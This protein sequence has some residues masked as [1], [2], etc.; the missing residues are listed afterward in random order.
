[1]Q[2]RILQENKKRG[3]IR[4]VNNDNEK[5]TNEFKIFRIL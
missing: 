3:G 5:I 1:M 2:Q 4:Y